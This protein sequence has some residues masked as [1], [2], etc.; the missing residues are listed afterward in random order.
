MTCLIFL[1]YGK[2]IVWGIPSHE[3]LANNNS[4]WYARGHVLVTLS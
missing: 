1:H 3:R 2:M 4:E